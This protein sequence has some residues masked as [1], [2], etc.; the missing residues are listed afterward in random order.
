[1][2]L[3]GTCKGKLADDT[4]VAFTY[5][6]DFD[7]CKESSRAGIAFTRGPIG[8]KGL[9]TGKR[10]FRNGKDLYLFPERVGLEFKDSTGNVG[11]I[12]R[13]DSGEKVKVSCQ[14]RDYEF[15]TEC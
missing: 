13:T 2:H 3:E 15:N 7:G 12:L 5:Y 4:T 10:Y 14:I 8:D 9:M 1:M 11:G 6:S